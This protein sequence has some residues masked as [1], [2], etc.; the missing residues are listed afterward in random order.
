M[1]LQI[2][3]F[4]TTKMKKRTLSEAIFLINIMSTKC[5]LTLLVNSIEIIFPLSRSSKT[6]NERNWNVFRIYGCLNFPFRIN[7]SI[8]LYQRM[9]AR[10]KEDRERQVEIVNH[11]WVV[12]P[13]SVFKCLCYFSDRML[14]DIF[15]GSAQR[16]SPKSQNW[17]FEVGSLFWSHHI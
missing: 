14:G 4:S 1:R 12:N 15:Q 16:T 10:E 9:M 2:S 3:I 7:S 11:I 17:S 6:N 5:H 8:V 13:I